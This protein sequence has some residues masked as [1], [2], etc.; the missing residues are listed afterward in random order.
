M[1]SGYTTVPRT[2]WGVMVPQ[3]FEE[4]QERAQEY[5]LIALAIALI[6]LATATLIAWLLSGLLTKPIEAVII[7]A[8]DLGIG[9]TNTRAALPG[10]I[11]RPTNYGNLPKI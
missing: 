4:L 8:R 2:G 3:P 5:Q 6:G 11:W 9:H 7:A 1:I 10:K